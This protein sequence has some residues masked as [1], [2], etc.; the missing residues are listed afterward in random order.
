MRCCLSVTEICTFCF[1][2]AVELCPGNII[3]LSGLQAVADTSGFGCVLLCNIIED[4]RVISYDFA[5]DDI[6]III[7]VITLAYSNIIDAVIF[8]ILVIL[9]G[10][11]NIFTDDIAVFIV[12]YSI[13]SNLR[14]SIVLDV[15]L[16]I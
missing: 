3:I 1:M 2:L 14:F 12:L 7:G 9:I 13:I 8:R 11:W 5:A 15:I 10:S 4:I 6:N 16:Y